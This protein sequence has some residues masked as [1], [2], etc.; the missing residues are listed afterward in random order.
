MLVLLDIDGTLL[1]NNHIIEDSTIETI[2]NFSSINQF[3]LCSARKPSSTISIAKQLKLKEKIIICY[4]GA[5]I[6]DGKQKILERPLT[7]EMVKH[8]WRIAQKHD[9]TI[10]FYSDDLWFV[11]NM[12]EFVLYEAGIVGEKP[13]KIE[14]YLKIEDLVIHKI[15][16]LGSEKKLDLLKDEL[17]LD[18][19]GSITLCNSKPEYLEITSSQASKKRAF[20]YLT[21]YLSVDIKDSLAIGDGYNDLELLQCV[22][23]GIAMDNSPNEVKRAVKYVTNSN[24][25]N[26]VGVALEKFLR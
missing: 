17:E 15:L 25:R 5:L 19:I 12:N 14:D 26:G 4:N 23:I 16:L 7:I 6:M 11:N 24:D 9:L 2:A 20:E 18:G 10:N 8:I 3:I 22:K 13:I 1:N 21:K